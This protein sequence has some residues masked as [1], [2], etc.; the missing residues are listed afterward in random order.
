MN[1]VIDALR[2]KANMLP[3]LPGVYIMLDDKSEVIYVGKAKKL[4][5]RVT[6]YFHGEHLPKVAAMVD[7]VRDFNVI[8]AGSEFEALILE[9]SLIKRH[10]PRY[11]ILLKDDKGYPFIRLDLRASY[12]K[13]EIASRPGN[14][15]ASYFGP[16]GGRGST[17]EII[18]SVNAALSLPD[19]SRRLP[20]EIGRQRPCL[21]VHIGRCDGWC[22][23]EADSSEYRHRIEQAVLILEGKSAELVDDLKVKME[24]AAED[25]RFEYAA[26]L[27]DRIKAVE[28]LSNR[29]MVISTSFT[30]TDAVAFCRGAVCCF[31]VLHFVGGDLAD[32]EVIITDEPLEDDYEA[33]PELL[34]QYYTPR[35]GS[36]PAHILIPAEIDGREALEQYLSEGNPRKVHIEV[37]QR[38]ERK[39]LSEMA[40][41]NASEEI[42]RRTTEEKRRNKTLELLQKMLS[43]E[44]LPERIEAFDVSN[45]GSTGI[46]CGMTVFLHG[47]PLKRDY[48][49]FRITDMPQQDDYASM[50]QAV[51]RRF[52]RYKDG[53]EKFSELPDLLLIDGGEIHAS[54]A[55]SALQNLGLHLPVFGM[56]KDDRHRTR[57]LVTPG[58]LEIGIQSNQAVFSFVGSVQEET[59]RFSIEYQRSLRLERYGSELDKIKGVGDKR[60]AA[61]LKH[62]KS[63]KAVSAATVKELMEVLPESS[64]NAVYNHFHK[65]GEDE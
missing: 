36:R 2:K 48:R 9:N 38:G 61:L 34:R 1:P 45:L 21:N 62:F 11:N 50:Y 60:R 28:A 47:K 18:S 30:D 65:C 7:K 19:C 39:R 42:I 56:V 13:M 35:E 33:L 4:K 37:P 25:L 15:G 49:K 64:A 43:L 46:V 51:Y 40:V 31:S 12:P 58:G 20:D 24:Q 8:V 14:D 10:K 59:H 26:S 44:T 52:R 27:R 55:E 17:N 16:Y 57:A 3:L 29:Q 63:V 54:T 32:K 6:S 53:D 22:T 41:I 5:N 23:P